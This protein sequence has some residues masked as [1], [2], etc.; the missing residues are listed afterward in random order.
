MYVS[1]IYRHEKP[2][3]PDDPLADQNIKDR[4]FGINDPVADKLMRRYDSMPK[5]DV[6]DDKFVT[7][8]YVGNLAERVTEKELKYVSHLITQYSVLLAPII[9]YS[10]QL[11][12]II[13]QARDPK[14]KKN[15]KQNKQK[16]RAER[17]SHVRRDHYVI[18]LV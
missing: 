11:N 5:L 8:L 18:S 3:D 4:F 14:N 6:P 2:T 12:F 17:Q 9:C 13:K 1:R 15:T 7:T 16:I 10:T